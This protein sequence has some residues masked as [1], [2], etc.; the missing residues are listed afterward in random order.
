MI[1]IFW[2]IEFFVVHVIQCIVDFG[3]CS[4][5][6][7]KN[8]KKN[9]GFGFSV[10]CVLIRSSSSTLLFRFSISLPISV[11]SFI[12]YC[13]RC[14]K[15]SYS[16]ANRSNS[17]SLSLSF[18]WPCYTAC[19]ILV[20]WPGIEFMPPAVEVQSINH[21]TT[22]KIPNSSFSCSNSC[23]DFIKAVF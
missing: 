7:Q 5:C 13:R 17:L 19:G 9:S 3:K 20:Y 8:L 12:S 2:N 6:T 16:T 22:V 10:I 15:L 14:V 21:W 4:T 18:F 23:F 11:S 1:S